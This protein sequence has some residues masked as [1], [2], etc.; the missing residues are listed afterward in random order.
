MNDRHVDVVFFPEQLAV[1]DVLRKRLHFKRFGTLLSSLIQHEM[2]GLTPWNKQDNEEVF[3]SI[4]GVAMI[5]EALLHYNTRWHIDVFPVSE[6]MYA[7]LESLKAAYETEAIA[8]VI[9][10]L[11]RHYVGAEPLKLA[12]R[13]RQELEQNND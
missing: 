2:I 10:G 6:E 5:T 7:Y 8:D 3:F 9:R 11:L 13:L 4:G 1:M 12:E